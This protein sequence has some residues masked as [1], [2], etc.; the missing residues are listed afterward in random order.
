MKNKAHSEEIPRWL[1]YIAPIVFFLIII[2][3]LAF[4]LSHANQPLIDEPF[5]QSQTAI[6]AFWFNLENPIQGLLNY[7]TPE[8]GP[9][10]Q[11]PM[12]FPLYQAVVAYICK[13]TGFPLTACGRM[14]SGIF[15]ILTLIPFYTICRG[16]GFGKRFFYCSSVLL[17]GSPIYIFYSRMFL[18]ES[19]AVFFGFVFLALLVKAL[20]EISAKLWLLAGFAAIL[21]GLV[22]VTTFPSFGVAAIGIVLLKNPITS[23]LN[24]KSFKKT[25]FFP[26]AK[27]AILGGIVVS[28]VAFWTYRA[29]AIKLSGEL[30]NLLTSNKLSAWN[31]GSIEQKLDWRLWRELLFGRVIKL[32]FGWSVVFGF[33]LAVSTLLRGKQILIF[34][35]FIGLFIIPML[36]FTNLHHVHP[37]YQTA[38]AFWLLF[39][40][41]LG[42]TAWSYKVDWRIFAIAIILIFICQL[43]SFYRGDY[44]RIKIYQND[45]LSAGLFI[46]ENS[47][48]E[49][50]LLVFG[51]DWSPEVSY[52]AERKA[53]YIPAWAPDK[54]AGQIFDRVGIEQSEWPIKVIVHRTGGY[55]AGLYSESL[56]QK[57]HQ[58][59]GRLQG[60]FTKTKIGEYDIFLLKTTNWSIN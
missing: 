50:S 59:L 14:V 43:Y 8:L 32:V 30:S 4:W 58:L 13:I 25:T 9:P 20:D 19:T 48:R 16:L 21:C 57:F 44:S 47:S 55:W 33:F 27:L 42:L 36:L 40:F 17:L 60:Q 29:D 35:W 46:Q 51:D 52:Y 18:I 56:N 12:E 15:F 38:N 5:R 28:I 45:S 49:D 3:V 1:Y 6:S 37:H 24:W 10:W 41:A 34:F 53:H 54:V 23:P 22:K 31:Y 7:E 2:S 11:I 39:A 26:L